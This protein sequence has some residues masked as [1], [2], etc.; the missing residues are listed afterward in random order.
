ME[1][2]TFFSGSGAAALD[3]ECIFSTYFFLTKV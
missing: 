3:E 2:G 1:S